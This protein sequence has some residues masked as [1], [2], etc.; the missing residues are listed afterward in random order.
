MVANCF[1]SVRNWVDIY[2][3]RRKETRMA[4]VRILLEN[5]F[6]HLLLAL[7]ARRLETIQQTVSFQ[8]A[9]GHGSDGVRHSDHDDIVIHEIS[10]GI[11]VCDPLGV[12]NGIA[13]AGSAD[14]C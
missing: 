8:L 13:R 2:P 4:D 12:S 5:I 7:H 6:R 1:G 14:S 11:I 3:C 10:F 9:H